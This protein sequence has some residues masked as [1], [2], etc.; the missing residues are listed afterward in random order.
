MKTCNYPKGIKSGLLASLIIVG[1]FFI[2]GSAFA[3]EVEYEHYSQKSRVEVTLN[4]VNDFGVI[5]I[6]DY[7]LHQVPGV[8]DVRQ[9]QQWIRPNRERTSQV[10]WRIIIRGEMRFI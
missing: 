5:R 6:F 8:S 4:G 3:H 7:L 1:L 10:V 2:S 9:T